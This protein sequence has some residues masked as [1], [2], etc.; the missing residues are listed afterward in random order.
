MRSEDAKLDGLDC[1]RM[2]GQF[3]GSPLTIWID[4]RAIL[5]RRIDSQKELDDLR[6]ERTT[7]YKPVIN[8]KISEK[9]LEFDPPKPD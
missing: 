1:F 5:V 4:K 6:T 3:G 2:Q 9:K 8:G 7:T